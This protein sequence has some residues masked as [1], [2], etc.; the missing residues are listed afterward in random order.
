M[1][2]ISNSFI[3]WFGDLKNEKNIKS[4]MNMVM[5]NNLFD[6]NIIDSEPPLTCL[7]TYFENSITILDL[8]KGKED[9]LINKKRGDVY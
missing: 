6:I 2:Y 5:R 7:M 8:I 3:I 4:L 1:D 9:F